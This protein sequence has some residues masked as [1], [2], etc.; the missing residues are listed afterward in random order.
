MPVKN[1]IKAAVKRVRK[2]VHPIGSE[3]IR[4][5]SS[6]SAKKR[7]IDNYRL[8]DDAFTLAIERKNRLKDIE[9]ILLKDNPLRSKKLLNIMRSEGK[10]PPNV[11]SKL[12]KFSKSQAKEYNY[13]FE[14]QKKLEPDWLKAGSKLDKYRK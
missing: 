2:R 12:D 14:R 9:N 6:L 4:Y 1:V 3:Y 8:I 10:I 13:W 7:A 5:F 11:I